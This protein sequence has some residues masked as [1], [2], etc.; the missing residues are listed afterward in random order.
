[1]VIINLV[2]LVTSSLRLQTG[3]RS[4]ARDPLTGRLSQMQLLAQV[5]MHQTST[6]HHRTCQEVIAEDV[7]WLAC[8]IDAQLRMTV[9]TR[10]IN[11]PSFQ[12]LVG[13]TTSQSTQ[14]N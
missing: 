10:F 11:T 1:M 6:S 14:F 2:I 5:T 7:A 9:I 3:R 12:L 4:C 13:S 8:P